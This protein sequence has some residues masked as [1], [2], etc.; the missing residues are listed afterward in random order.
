MASMHDPVST[1]MTTKLHAVAPSDPLTAVKELFEK[2][3]FHHIPVVRYK[4]LV[5]MVSKSDFLLIR[6]SPLEA[7][8][9]EDD[10]FAK[11]RV[12]EVM[13]TRLAKIEPEDQIG[14]A[15][16]V[17]LSNRFHAVPVVKDGELVGLVTTFDIINY[18]LH[19]AYPNT[20][21]IFE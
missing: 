15:A 11:H 16:E 20:K 8:P 7:M 3:H 13:T 12:E 10:V 5:G 19:Q 6:H 9:V 17:L 18:A 21:T 14:T 2:H 4:E 1:I